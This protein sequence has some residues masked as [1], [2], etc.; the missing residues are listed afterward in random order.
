MINDDRSLDSLQNATTKIKS[1]YTH[2]A[3]LWPLQIHDGID[4][5]THKQHTTN[6]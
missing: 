2:Y 4:W 6:K 3:T 5:Y 1:G